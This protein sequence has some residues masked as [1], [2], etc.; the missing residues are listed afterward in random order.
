[1]ETPGIDY[2]PN[3]FQAGK[4]NIKYRDWHYFKY[5]VGGM[6]LMEK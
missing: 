4:Q 3:T 6:A 2:I 1:L 5:V